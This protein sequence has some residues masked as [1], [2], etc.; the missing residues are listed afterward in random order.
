MS[1]YY[2]RTILGIGVVILVFVIGLVIMGAAV[3]S[4]GGE[5]PPPVALIVLVLPVLLAIMRVRV[6][7]EAVRLSF[8][9]GLLRRTVPVADIVGVDPV[10]S[11]IETG[12]GMSVKPMQGRYCLSGPQAVRLRLSDGRSVLIGVP[13]ASDLMRAGDKARTRSG[14][15]DES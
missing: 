8:P 12:F 5:G 9:I 4:E 15:R 11:W 1:P 3:F 13:D 14:A 7:R 6:D 2:E 10:H